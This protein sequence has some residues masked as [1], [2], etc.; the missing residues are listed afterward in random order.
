MKEN[1][2]SSSEVKPPESISDNEN[3]SE[4]DKTTEE[5]TEEIDVREKLQ[6][7]NITIVTPAFISSSGLLNAA[8]MEVKAEII[9]FGQ[10]L[11]ESE[12]RMQDIEENSEKVD[13]KMDESDKK[14]E[15]LN[16]ALKEEQEKRQKEKEEADKKLQEAD[17]K[18]ET[19]QNS[20]DNLTNLVKQLLSQNMSNN[21]NNVEYTSKITANNGPG[22]F[23]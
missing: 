7:K 23:K 6:E 13:K 22:F 19:L 2:I 9:R 11:V 3:K 18:V 14:I 16:K 15:E 12:Y 1:N 4:I 10:F 8:S 5:I 17:K 21:S 20:V